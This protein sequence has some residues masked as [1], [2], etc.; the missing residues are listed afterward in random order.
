[1]QAQGETSR[2]AAALLNL[3]K[4]KAEKR[5]LLHSSR[6]ISNVSALIE[7]RRKDAKAE[8]KERTKEEIEGGT[9]FDGGVS[10]H[11]LMKRH[12]EE[13]ATAIIITCRTSEAYLKKSAQMLANV[14][15]EKALVALNR[16]LKNQ[17]NTIDGIYV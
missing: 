7:S 3:D 15:S 9:T 11:D 17:G 1:M 10:V 13:Y 6:D 8:S 2:R 5:V 16:K 4:R 14:K 12:Q